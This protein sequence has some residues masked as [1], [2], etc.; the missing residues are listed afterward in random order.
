[1]ALPNIF[2]KNVT[3]GLI[4]RINKLKTDSQPEWGKMNAPQM[5]AH[6]NVTYEMAYTDKHP[7]PNF[8]MKFILK[9]FVKNIVVGEKPYKRN[10]QTAP[11]FLITDTRDFEKERKRLIDYLNQ[12]Q[13]LGEKSFDKKES[14]SFGKLSIEEWNNMFYKHL[15]HHLTQF[16]V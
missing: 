2:D 14:N 16:G 13:A 4:A 11:A 3:E 1:M 6:C 12:T 7:K 8:F 10:S 5:L 15:D 9:L